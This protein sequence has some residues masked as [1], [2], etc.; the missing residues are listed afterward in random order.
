MTQPP[1]LSPRIQR[2]NADYTLETIFEYVRV[3]HGRIDSN[4]HRCLLVDAEGAFGTLCRLDRSTITRE[5]AA[6]KFLKMCIN[7]SKKQSKTV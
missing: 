3:N 2:A 5:N 6:K 1:P 4:T 7:I